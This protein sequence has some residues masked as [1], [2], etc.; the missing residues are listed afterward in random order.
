[1]VAPPA[2]NTPFYNH[3]RSYL[4]KKLRPPPPIYQPELVA[5][6][7]L[8]AATSRRR[9]VKV[10]EQTVALSVGNKL[11]P[12]VLDFFAGV[13]G[14]PLQLADFGAAV[15]KQVP[16]LNRPGRESRTHGDF[17]AESASVSPQFWLLR[18]SGLV[19][20][21]M[22]AGGAA[23]LDRA[24]AAQALTMLALVLGGGNALGAYHGGV[25]EA[26]A[27]E[28]VWP[29]WIAGSSIGAIMGALIA[30]NPPE[31]R[32]A[33][34]REFW[35]RGALRDPVA[36]WL[37]DALRKPVHFT[38]A[39]QARVAGRPQLYHLRLGEL[40]GGDGRPGLYDPAP[41][42]RALET[43][44]DFD[45][46]NR[47]PIRLT[48]L[49]VDVETGSEV[50]FDS[51]RERIGVDHLL[52]S[53]ALIPDFPAVPIGNR[54]LADGG[55]AA[56]VPVDL[57][58]AETAGRAARLLQRGSV[59]AGGAAPGPAGRRGGAAD[60]PHLRGADDAHAAGDALAVA[61]EGRRAARGGLLP[62]LPA[63]GGRGRAEEL[64]FRAIEPRP[65]LVG[66]PPRYGAGAAG[67]ARVAAGGDRTDAPSD[68]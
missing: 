39:L 54:L 16:N 38:A 48:M 13:I 14:V 25:A 60:R 20:A 26:L 24:S 11:L 44:V 50:S 22:A 58:L 23:W 30:G 59:P 63:L 55:L 31:R 6:A 35:N 67:L 52:A 19:G 4:R 21:V 33:A 41:M 43:L 9:E 34:I 62:E 27:A 40:L 7:I 12:G 51:Q 45:L 8:L 47:G 42:R 17:D 68:R 2:T 18:H 15:A 65:P 5:D 49:A 32:V 3:A 56:N 61:G 37:P 64:R 10:G 53:A 28:G 57:V 66:G 1:M 36:D 46:L 29:D